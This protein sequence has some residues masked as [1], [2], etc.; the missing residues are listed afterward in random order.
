MPMPAP[1]AEFSD[2]VPDWSHG[3]TGLQELPIRSAQI[4]LHINELSKLKHQSVGP[5]GTAG[6][7]KLH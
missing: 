5:S 3:L 4:T 7:L 2:E 1:V 6:P